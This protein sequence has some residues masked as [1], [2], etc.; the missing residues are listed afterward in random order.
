MAGKAGRS[1]RKKKSGT[2]YRFD[3]YYRIIPGEDPPELEALLQA[4]VRARGRKRRDI[5]QAA[6][7]GGIRPGQETA[8][9]QEDSD[10]T[11]MIDEMFGDFLA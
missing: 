1:G 7:L 2:V 6:L 11:G 9:R 3:F 10:T 4:I 8:A 5:L